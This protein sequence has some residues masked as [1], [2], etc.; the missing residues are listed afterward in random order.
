MSQLRK[1]SRIDMSIG[2]VNDL[3]LAS[4]VI[5]LLERDWPKFGDLRGDLDSRK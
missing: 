3:S 5:I 4:Y 2:R 1:F